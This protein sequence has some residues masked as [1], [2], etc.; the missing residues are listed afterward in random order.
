LVKTAYASEWRQTPPRS[1][2]S[3]RNCSVRTPELH[4]ACRFAP[5][6]CA[7]RRYEPLHWWRCALRG[8]APSRAQCGHPEFLFMRD[9]SALD[10][11][12]GTR[13]V[14]TRNMF[15]RIPIRYYSRRF[16]GHIMQRIAIAIG[17]WL[18]ISAVAIGTPFGAAF[19]FT[20]QELQ[21]VF[22]ILDSNKTGKVDRTEYDQNKVAAMFWQPKLGSMEMGELTFE[23]TKFNRA[24]FDSA[25]TDHKGRLDGVDLI[26]A[27][28]FE[29]IDVDRK[30][31]ITIDDLRRFMNEAGR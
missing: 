11:C 14:S 22:A 17:A 9:V 28:Q 8:D 10:S 25:D 27:L 18:L 4:S 29:K 2:L 31:Y 19:A 21:R 12:R 20:E 23:D 30:G 15:S 16:G 26:Y 7:E 24:F 13:R 3:E 6:I 1:A 5:P